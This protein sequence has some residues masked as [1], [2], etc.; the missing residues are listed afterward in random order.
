M[1]LARHGP[2]L[3]TLL[4]SA[5]LLAAPAAAQE[6]SARSG[7]EVLL[8]LHDGTWLSGVLI[9]Q[10]PTG[11]LVRVESDEG[12]RVVPFESVSEIR[13]AGEGETRPEPDGRPRRAPEVPPERAAA[14]RF[15]KLVDVH[16]DGSSD[17]YELRPG[18]SRFDDIPDSAW[19]GSWRTGSD[20]R[21]L[22]DKGITYDV[23]GFYE[24]IGK[25]SAYRR[26]RAAGK[27]A[28]IAANVFFYGGWIVGGAG[29]AGIAAAGLIFVP[30]VV[31]GVVMLAV[32]APIIW[33]TARG[34][35]GYHKPERLHEEA[36][37][38][39]REQRV[40][41]ITLFQ[42]SLPSPRRGRASTRRVE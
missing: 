21:L 22:D 1:K 14:R 25:G 37:F 4:V 27:A 38:W 33:A 11:Y 30:M 32:V 13:R 2:A 39:T 16:E 24:A 41:Q 28:G 20:F 35:S 12:T 17:I 6:P 15:F 9:D 19:R 36:V 7:D 8:L 40:A 10:V 3:L 34:A 29:G 23:E 26:A 5:V 18:G 42:V 31:A